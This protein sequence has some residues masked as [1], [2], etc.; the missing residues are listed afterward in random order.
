MKTVGELVV[1]GMNGVCRIEDIKEESFSGN[2][3]TYYILRPN[4]EQGNNRIFVPADN[5]K[6][7]ADMKD[8]L[9]GKALI[10]LVGAVSPYAEGEWPSD[11]RAR[12]KLCRE[13]LAIGDREQLIRLIKTVYAEGRTPSASEE[14]AALRASILLYGEFSLSLQLEKADVIPFV[15][16]KRIP[17]IRN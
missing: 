3:R 5:E 17:P 9:T 13:T 12:S 8:V 6:L 10:D 16:G 1:Y 2:A 7:V 14:S 11:G 4:N 15:C